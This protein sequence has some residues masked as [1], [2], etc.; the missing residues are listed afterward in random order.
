MVLHAQS[1]PRDEWT[2]DVRRNWEAAYI[3]DIEI[4]GFQWNDP[5]RLKA[6]SLTSEDENEHEFGFEDGWTCSLWL[7]N[8]LRRL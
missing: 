3:K 1:I 5:K 2:T 6:Q 4:E 8:Y 7:R